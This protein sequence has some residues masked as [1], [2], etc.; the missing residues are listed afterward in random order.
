MND[1]FTIST[2]LL[3]I[4]T[5]RHTVAPG[6]QPACSLVVSHF[7][8]LSVGMAWDGAHGTGNMDGGGLVRNGK[9]TDRITSLSSF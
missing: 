5:M 7:F 2:L 8:G 3:D 1:I 4:S 6:T 9:R